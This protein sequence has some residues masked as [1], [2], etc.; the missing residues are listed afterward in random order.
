MI[1]QGD[2]MEFLAK[3][4]DQES[5]ISRSFRSRIINH[6]IHLHLQQLVATLVDLLH[7]LGHLLP[8]ALQVIQ[9]FFALSF[10]LHNFLRI[11]FFS[12][13]HALLQKL[14]LVTQILILLL[15]TAYLL[16][17]TTVMENQ[18][19]VFRSDRLQMLM[20][21]QLSSSLQTHQRSVPLIALRKHVHKVH[22]QRRISE[23]CFPD[24]KDDAMGG[25]DGVSFEID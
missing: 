23:R 11:F 19:F 20:M 15:K 25:V 13:G 24:G 22:R 10:H 9:R 14:P 8:L 17:Q 1:I 16:V 7:Y 18:F 5:I 12:S 3:V 21:L 4:I 2:K 6:L